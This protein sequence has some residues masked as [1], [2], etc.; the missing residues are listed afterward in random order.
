M[1]P[2]AIM[3]KPERER[4]KERETNGITCTSNFTIH[5]LDTWVN[6]H[7]DMSTTQLI[8]VHIYTTCIL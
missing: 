1:A 4:E 3:K 7:S 8:I 5:S 6:G 2:L